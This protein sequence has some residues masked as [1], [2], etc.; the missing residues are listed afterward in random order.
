[1]SLI[2]EVFDKYG[3]SERQEPCTDKTDTRASVS[4]VSESPKNFEINN[5]LVVSEEKFARKLMDRGIDELRELAG[6]D[7]EELTENRGMMIVF[8]SNVAR[9]QIRDSGA[10]PD[11]YTATTDCK[12][13]G[14]VPIHAGCPPIVDKCPWC[15]CGQAPPN[16]MN[17]LITTKSPIQG[18]NIEH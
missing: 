18:R 12:R 17:Q 5:A 15:V 10:I 3:I 7:W 1:M 13:C 16:G 6:D 9:R 2:Q 11:T 14:L 4:S 8:A